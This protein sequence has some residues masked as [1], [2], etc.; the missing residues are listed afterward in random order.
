MGDRE[1]WGMK[2]ILPKI[3]FHIM[4]VRLAYTGKII[5]LGLKIF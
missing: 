1:A 5:F 4:A 2:F 3:K